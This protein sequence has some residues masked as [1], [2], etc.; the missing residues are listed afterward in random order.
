M[1]TEITARP[2][3]RKAVPGKPGVYARQDAQ[4][5]IRYEITFRDSTGKQRWKTVEGGVTAA[6]HAR[7]DI[8]A[9]MRRGE[10][11]VSSRI[12]FEE[13]AAHWLKQKG[14]IT[15]HSWRW[16]ELALRRHVVP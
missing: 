8:L 3:Q 13:L 9:K 7:Q 4:G 15:E 10:R 11:V 12:T 1:Q 2:G 6:V 16:Y 5:R 14:N